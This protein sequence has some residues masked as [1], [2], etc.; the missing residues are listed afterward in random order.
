MGF[1]LG[2]NVSTIG[3]TL[4]SRRNPPLKDSAL[5]VENEQADAGQDG[6]TRIAR[7]NSQAQTG[8]RKYPFFPVQLTTRIV[9]LT[10]LIHI[11]L[12]V[13]TIHTCIYTHC[14][15]ILIARQV[16]QNRGERTRYAR[17]LVM[18]YLYCFFIKFRCM[19]RVQV[20]VNRRVVQRMG[21][22]DSAI[23]FPGLSPEQP[24]P[25]IRLHDPLHGRQACPE[26]HS[27]HPRVGQ[28]CP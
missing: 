25:G 21:G 16:H 27:F 6:R 23:P 3:S 11:L 14:T 5:S 24:L 7:P 22:G 8:A 13:M 9:N 20:L 26:F 28:I 1:R 19:D 4:F 2:S 18:S 10:R 17:Y 15:L 12:Q